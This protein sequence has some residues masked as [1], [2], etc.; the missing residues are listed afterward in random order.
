MKGIM[1]REWHYDLRDALSDLSDVGKVAGRTKTF[2]QYIFYLS[3]A[4]EGVPAHT[5]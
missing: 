4:E 1:T 5:L 3:N 2:E